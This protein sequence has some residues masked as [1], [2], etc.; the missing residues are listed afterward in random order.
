MTASTSSPAL[1]PSVA[2]P[3]TADLVL[4]GHL[5]ARAVLAL[6]AQV[7]AAVVDGPVLV[8]LDV[9]AVDRV[10]PSGVAGV[11]DLGRVARAAGGDL[12]LHGLSRAVAHAHAALRL[13]LV[14]RVYGGRAA[15]LAT[16]GT[17]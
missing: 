16:A 7:A 12:R 4:V 14:T 1:A 15:A 10:T 5:D 13:D 3:R 8:L 17:P 2:H 11:L 9:S 6:R